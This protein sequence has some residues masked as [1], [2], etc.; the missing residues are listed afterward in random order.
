MAPKRLINLLFTPQPFCRVNPKGH[1]TQV[2]PTNLLEQHVCFTFSSIVEGVTERYCNFKCHLS[3]LTIKTLASL[4]K[5][6]FLNTTERLKQEKMFKMTSF[7]S[8]K[9]C[10]VYLII[11]APFRHVYIT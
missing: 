4:N 9:I 1:L 3:Q 11:A 7:L 8:L 5:N 2:S 6:V 10:S